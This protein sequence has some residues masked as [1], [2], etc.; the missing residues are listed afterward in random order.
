VM[1]MMMMTTV[2]KALMEPGCC[3]LVSLHQLIL[4]GRESHPGGGP[5]LR[6]RVES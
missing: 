1:M 3:N 6:V 5:T 4:M 2:M